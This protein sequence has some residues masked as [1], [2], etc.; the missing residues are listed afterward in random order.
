M[1]SQVKE[2]LP[3]QPAQVS[4]FAANDHSFNPFFAELRKAIPTEAANPGRARSGGGKPRDGVEQ[5]E[6]AQHQPLQAEGDQ[7]AEQNRRDRGNDQRAKRPAQC[8]H[9]VWFLVEH[10]AQEQPGQEAHADLRASPDDV[11]Q[12]A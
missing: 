5:I 1:T 3:M 10:A 8:D 6:A 9:F 2:Y 7:A 11:P 12:T 4:R